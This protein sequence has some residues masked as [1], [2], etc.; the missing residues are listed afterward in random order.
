MKINWKQYYQVP[1]TNKKCYTH[2]RVT[3][4]ERCRWQHLQ[5]NLDT[6]SC[7]HRRAISPLHSLINS[8]LFPAACCVCGAFI[9]SFQL[10]CWESEFI[11]TVSL[12][13][14]GSA[15]LSSFTV[16]LLARRL[17]HTS[18]SLPIPTFTLITG[19]SKAG[20]PA[21]S[22]SYIEALLVFFLSYR[23]YAAS[24]FISTIAIS[25]APSSAGTGCDDSSSP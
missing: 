4:S 9:N 23:S 25:P 13:C 12:A 18:G 2:G 19:S 5:H 20:W 24:T 3:C 14:L 6:I 15:G 7:S 16:L 22:Y 1:C 21:G 8:I 17:L 11:S 10:S